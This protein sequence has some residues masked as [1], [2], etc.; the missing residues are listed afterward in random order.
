MEFTG[1][2]VIT[3]AVNASTEISSP[4]SKIMKSLKNKE[5]D[6]VDILSTSLFLCQP[7]IDQKDMRSGALV[8]SN[9]SNGGIAVGRITEIKFGIYS[10]IETGVESRFS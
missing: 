4:F 8:I 1:V 2:P 7:Y 3:S 10:S 5:K 9:K 6:D